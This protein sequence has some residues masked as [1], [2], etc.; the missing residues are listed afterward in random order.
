MNTT[1]LTERQIEVLEDLAAIRD[2]PM[3]CSRRSIH[4]ERHGIPA[5]LAWATPQ[6]IGAS[7][8][9][10]HSGTATRLAK[11]G[12]VDRY[13]YDGDQL[14]QFKTRNKGAC[15]YRITQAGLDVLTALRGQTNDR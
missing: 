7:D 1:A 5:G 6:D 13:K 11:L 2:R 4:S 10:H 3:Q 8:G 12:L 15:V 9:S 14:N